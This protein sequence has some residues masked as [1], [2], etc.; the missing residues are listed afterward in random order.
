M[1]VANQL[2][3]QYATWGIGKE[4]TPG[5]AVTPTTFYKVSSFKA[6]ANYDKI[7]PDL[8]G[9]A[10]TASGRA[11]ALVLDGKH[12][13]RFDVTSPL[14]IPGFGHVLK[15]ALGTYQGTGS[16]DPYTHT[17]TGESTGLLPSY[18]MESNVASGMVMRM[19]G[20]HL[21]TLE[22]SCAAGGYATWRAS[23]F[24][25]AEDS[26]SG[27][28]A[29]FPTDNPLTWPMFSFEI[30]D[31]S[32]VDIE[33]FTL[34]IENN[35]EEWYA[36][37]SN[38]PQRPIASQRKVSGELVLGYTSNDWFTMM[39]ENT[40]FKLEILGTYNEDRTISIVLPRCFVS[41]EPRPEIKPGRLVSTIPFVAVYDPSATYDISIVLTNGD[42]TSVY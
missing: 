17:F 39:A 26:A 25:M 38:D 37:G 15:G 11:I 35:L 7:I 21:N 36:A 40:S 24:G 30:D 2:L 4:A 42:N 9:G 33:S 3:G 16:S 31:V 12:S 10:T 14:W 27:A 41:T 13:L 23:Y 34:T 32:N 28:T 8:V 18:T 29:S 6:A 5:T 1:P 20:C 19:A 22:I